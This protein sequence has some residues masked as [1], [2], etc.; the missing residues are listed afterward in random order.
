MKK[1]NAIVFAAVATVLLVGGCF[2]FSQLGNAPEEQSVVVAPEIPVALHGELVFSTGEV[3][4]SRSEKWL[5]INPGEIL[6]EGDNLKT[7]ALSKATILFDDGSI[8]RLDA[9]TEIVI[10][11]IQ[12]S[13]IK[14]AEIKGSTYNRVAKADDR[15]YIVS[16][17]GVNV[18]ALGTAFLLEVKEKEVSVSMIEN[19][20]KVDFDNGTQEVAQGEKVKINIEKKEIKKESLDKAV[21]EKEQFAVWNKTEDETEK[22]EM[23]IWQKTVEEET[24]KET[25]EEKTEPKEVVEK[26]DPETVTSITLA[27]SGANVSWKVNG[28]SAQGFKLVWSKN[29]EPTYPTRSGDKYLYYTDSATRYGKLSAFDGAGTYFV[30]VCEYLGGAC[31]KYSNQISVK[32]EVPAEKD[33]P[34]VSE[35]VKSI[36]MSATG[37]SVKWSVNGLSKNGFKIVWSKNENPTY[38]TRTGDQ[39]IYLSSPTASSTTLSAFD[40]AGTYFVRVCEYLGGACGVYSNQS[41]VTL[42]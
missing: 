17:N 3:Y 5:Q 1:T 20:S 23:G 10:E 16:A 41:T 35:T 21:L 37:S 22:Y 24:V 31:G 12:K 18:T 42:E 26:K 11:K 9:E 28:I 29:S 32:L 40:G 14:I 7:N 39:Y 34:E 4:K 38:P 33:V 19:K 36:S 2:A 8:L 15:N 30:R 25:A 27:G 6:N 13:E